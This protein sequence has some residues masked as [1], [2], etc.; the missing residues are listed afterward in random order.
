MEKQQGSEIITEE[1][2]GT[3]GLFLTFKHSLVSLKKNVLG[4][5]KP[6]QSLGVHH[7]TGIFCLTN[8]LPTVPK[9]LEALFSL[10]PSRG[11]G[12]AFCN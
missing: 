7:P 9:S 4:V 3:E 12:R 8:Y 6:V 5:F 11:T 1:R 10:L 2:G